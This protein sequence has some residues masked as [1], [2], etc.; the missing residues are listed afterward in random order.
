MNQLTPAPPESSTSP[1]GARAA[2]RLLRAFAKRGVRAAFGI[3]GG[4]IGPVYD[5]L[6][7]VPEI[8]FVATRHETTAV[9]AAI[10]HARATGKPALV[11]VT[12]G[13]GLTNTLT[14]VASAHVEEAPLIILA[15]D[16]ATTWSARGAFQDGSPSGLDVIALM[17]SVTRFS[18]TA[19]PVNVDGVMARAWAEATGARPGPVFLN[20]PYDVGQTWGAA[21]EIFDAVHE[22]SRDP[23][24][25]ACRAAAE[26]LASAKRPLLVL[27]AGARNAS[28]AAIALAERAASPVVVTSHAKGAFPERHPLYAGL[29]GN[30]GHSSAR[31]YVLSAPDVVCIVGSR[32]GDFATNAWSLPIAGRTATIQI[33]RDPLYIGRN[34][35]VTLGIVGDARR[36][37]ESIVGNMPNA[38]PERERVALRTK[39]W[40]VSGPEGTVKPH[41][42]VLAIGEAFG[43]ATFCSDIG[44]HM[45]FAQHYLCVDS[46]DRFHC[47]S[48]LGAMGSGIGSAIG[49]KQAQPD[50]R[51]IAFVG[52]G[53]FNMHVGELLTCVER[54]IGVVFVVFNDGRWNMVEHGFRAIFK[55]MPDHLPQAVADLATVARAYGADAVTIDRSEQLDADVLRSLPRKGV[56][57]VLDVR[58]DPNES[59][60]RATRSSTFARIGVE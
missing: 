27:G 19:Y 39:P 55:R 10:G 59:L 1:R 36:A 49:I 8:D 31:D 2:T 45:G 37:L 41:Q 26:L 24:A 56:P 4:S 43:D 17:R 60:S 6:A 18:A 48:G 54:G 23:D 13:P 38:A 14:G 33:D 44:E 7:D 20:V 53:G 9:F 50:A 47:M 21:H 35:P 30:A 5:A 28:S 52:D 15:G 12:S 3:P 16:V 29:I 32:L 34:A 25:A 58:V 46:A 22:P 51:V 42:V 40:N 11:L 57:L